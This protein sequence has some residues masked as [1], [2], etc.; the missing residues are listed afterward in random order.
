MDASGSYMGGTH[1]MNFTWSVSGPYATDE[2]KDWLQTETG[3]VISVPWNLTQTGEWE[4]TVVATNYLGYSSNA[5]FTVR[6]F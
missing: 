1:P 5:S 6:L 3:P 2:L 4:F